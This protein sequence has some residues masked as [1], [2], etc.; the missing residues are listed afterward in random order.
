[1]SKC[2]FTEFLF[3]NFSSINEVW[4]K[5]IKKNFPIGDTKNKKSMY[6]TAIKRNISKDE[7]LIASIDEKMRHSKK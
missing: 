7:I 4:C 2:L 5:Q 3:L 1:M 6:L